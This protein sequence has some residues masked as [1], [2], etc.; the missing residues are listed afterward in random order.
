G[1]GRADGRDRDGK[2][3]PQRSVPSGTV[4]EA[5]RGADRMTGS[6]SGKVAVVTGST[7]GLGAAIAT[8]FVEPGARVVLTGRSPDNGE[9]VRRRL[10]SNAVFQR[11]D[12]SRAED[13]R[14][15][16]EAGLRAF[17]GIDILVNSAAD[18]SRSTVDDLTPEFI[19][20]QVAINLKAPLLLARHAA[21]SL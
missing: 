10:G 12:L 2:S 13:C 11:A 21:P 8:L 3:P 18:S 20:R 5:F 9:E 14:G 15:V 1:R 4:R 19:D 7:Q 6:L 17:D 16:I